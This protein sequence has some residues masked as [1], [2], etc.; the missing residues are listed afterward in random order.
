MFY[1]P[2]EASK[3]FFSNL[4]SP[5]VKVEANILPVYNSDR[6][7]KE[8]RY[9]PEPDPDRFEMADDIWT[10]QLEM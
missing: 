6:K 2:D 3:F 10:E 9:F 7:K 1:E 5:E 8:V 4:S